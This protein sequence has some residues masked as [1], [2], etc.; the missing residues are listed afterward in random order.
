MCTSVFYKSHNSTYIFKTKNVLYNVFYKDLKRYF[1]GLLKNVS[2]CHFFGKAEGDIH[3]R[4]LNE[5]YFAS[6]PI[7]L[8]ENFYCFPYHIYECLLSI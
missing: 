8:V 4:K 3:L 1:E 2:E 5:N 7:Y 6:F